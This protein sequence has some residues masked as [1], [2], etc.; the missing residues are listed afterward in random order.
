MQID[1]K[2][3]FTYYLQDEKWTNKLIVLCVISIFA[4]IFSGITGNYW[5]Y[6]PSSLF[7]FGYTALLTN[8]I[9]NEKAHKLPDF[10][11]K[12]IFQHGF[13]YATASFSYIFMTLCIF[14]IIFI[15]VTL[16]LLAIALFTKYGKSE[17]ATL[18]MFNNLFLLI[19][20][21]AAFVFSWVSLQFLQLTYGENLKFR[22][23][24]NFKRNAKLFFNAKNSFIPILIIFGIFAMSEQNFLQLSIFWINKPFFLSISSFFVVINYFLF[25][26]STY[27]FAQSYKI[28][29]ARIEGSFE[30]QE[31]NIKTRNHNITIVAAMII[32]S[33]TM[34]TASF[35]FP[36]VDQ[37]QMKQMTGIDLPIPK[38][39]KNTSAEN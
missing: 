35:T 32:L 31:P 28:S 14:A 29:L 8:N 21:L 24:F 19:S 16:I 34:V 7:G 25:F 22:D 3:A 10:H 12:K 1:F 13:N 5:I 6:V 2:K 38:T 9:L 27:L 17:M 33:L 4:T 15:S 30:Y 18:K 37:K 36:K 26:A 20:L 39:T 23:I 11:L